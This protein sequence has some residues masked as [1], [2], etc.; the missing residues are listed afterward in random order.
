MRVQ[1]VL[2]RAFQVEAEAASFFKLIFKLFEVPSHAEGVCFCLSEHFG[3]KI[4][5]FVFFIHQSTDLM[6]MLFT[7]KKLTKL[8]RPVHNYERPN[9]L[10]NMNIFMI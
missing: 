4:K 9:I 10:M 1:R 2:S 5:V 8:H 3:V 7:I 6:H